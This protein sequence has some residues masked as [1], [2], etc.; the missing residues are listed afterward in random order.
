MKRN[1]SLRLEELRRRGNPGVAPLWANALKGEERIAALAG[2]GEGWA[3]LLKAEGF[4]I[5]GRVEEARKALFSLSGLPP[6]LEAIRE[7]LTAKAAEANE[8]GE[9]KQLSKLESWLASVRSWRKLDYNKQAFGV[10][11]E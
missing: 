5:L 6:T 10:A 8:S 11:A 3:V 4:L 1:T 9:E 2:R 7:E